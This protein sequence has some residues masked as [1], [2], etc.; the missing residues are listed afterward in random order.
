[1]TLQTLAVLQ[2]LTE[3]KL[4]IREKLQSGSAIPQTGKYHKKRALLDSLFNYA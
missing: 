3:G 2:D 4:Q 1:M